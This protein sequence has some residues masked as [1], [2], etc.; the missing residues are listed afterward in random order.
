MRPGV[1][2]DLPEQPAGVAQ[3][4]AEQLPAR[5]VGVAGG[6][7]RD[8]RLLHPLARGGEG[9][10]EA[11]EA[12]GLRAQRLAV[13]LCRRGGG[14]EELA[15]ARA[16]PRRGAGIGACQVGEG[17]GDPPRLEGGV[18]ERHQGGALAVG[19]AHPAAPPGVVAEALLG[20]AEALAAL[21][22]G[23]VEHPRLVQPAV[24]ARAVPA[25]G[26]SP[27]DLGEQR[28]DALGERGEA[29]VGERGEE[30]RHHQQVDH[31]RDG[32][33][34]EGLEHAV[35]GID[36]RLGAEP[37]HQQR[38]HRHLDRLLPQPQHQAE[39]ES[40]RGEQADGP[41]VHAEHTGGEQREQHP[42]DD[43]PGPLQPHGQ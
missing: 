16:E 25:L 23:L 30:R 15:E 5:R 21:V 2:V 39:R 11:V 26:E 20:L 31:H 29:Q 22:E 35:A 4:R 36:V 10:A 9:G 24:G 13:A 3:Q 14:G 32:A 34:E 37:E 33:A 1:R 12:A 27:G 18:L 7:E 42:G 19:V 28:G 17:S 40:P 38:A 41:G 43:R 6:L 8:R